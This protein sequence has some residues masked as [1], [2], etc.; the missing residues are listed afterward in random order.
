MNKDYE[1]YQQNPTLMPNPAVALARTAVRVNLT[2]TLNADEM[3]CSRYQVRCW[4]YE[5]TH[6]TVNGI[7]EVVKNEYER[8]RIRIPSRGRSGQ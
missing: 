5:A 4:I 2:S 1:V 7:R 8:T 3:M 6:L